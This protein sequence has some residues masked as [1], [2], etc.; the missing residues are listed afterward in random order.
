MELTTSVVH[1][2]ALK[3]P[4][5]SCRDSLILRLSSGFSNKLAIVYSGYTSILPSVIEISRRHIFSSML[6]VSL[7]AFYARYL[8]RVLALIF[9]A[10]IFL[11]PKIKTLMRHFFVF[12]SFSV[13]LAQPWNN[14]SSTTGIFQVNRR[15]AITL[16]LLIK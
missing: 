5:E 13:P 9:C 4:G 7:R 12:F 2:R 11:R 14:N 10:C 3:D 16:A 8:L 1:S 6:L 15:L